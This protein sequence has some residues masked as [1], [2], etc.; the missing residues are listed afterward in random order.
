MTVKR[1][2]A[3]KDNKVTAKVSRAVALSYAGLSQE[4]IAELEGV[5]TRA[6][7]ARINRGLEDLNLKDNINLCNQRLYTFLNKGLDEIEAIFDLAMTTGKG[8]TV[9]VK[10]KNAQ[11]VFE[12]TLGYFQRI[13]LARQA[14]MSRDN[15]PPPI[16]EE[17]E[18]LLF[19]GRMVRLLERRQQ[20][21]EAEV[22]P[23]DGGIN[24]NSTVD[25]D[26]DAVVVDSDNAEDDKADEARPVDSSQDD[27]QPDN[28]PR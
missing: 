22:I 25:S 4:E 10:L 1:K 23:N 19:E 5:T 24:G 6:I 2:P 27:R 8:G 16:S 13:E 14:A 9:D 18:Q 20:L 12:K 7:Q 21:T 17:K 28:S 15:Q 3:I 26:G 11:F